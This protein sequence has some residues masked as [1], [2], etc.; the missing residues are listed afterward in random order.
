MEKN[1]ELTA[2]NKFL[3]RS[4]KNPQV[5]FQSVDLDESALFE[6]RTLPSSDGHQKIVNN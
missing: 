5:W 2:L 1:N 3:S 4:L 6:V